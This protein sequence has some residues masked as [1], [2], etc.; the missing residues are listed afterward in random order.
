MLY[1]ANGNGALR[2]RF[3]ATRNIPIDIAPRTRDNSAV[4]DRGTHLIAANDNERKAGR[5]GRGSKKKKEKGRLR[6]ADAAETTA[7]WFCRTPLS[8]ICLYCQRIKHR[9]CAPAKR[10]GDA[11]GSEHKFAWFGGADRR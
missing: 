11:R 5:K 10:V 3:V 6:R 2:Y 9:R 1:V 4:S 8:I 7:A